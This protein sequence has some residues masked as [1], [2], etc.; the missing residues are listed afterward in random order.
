[1]KKIILGALALTMG[2]YVQAQSTSSVSQ[3]GSGNSGDV[4]QTSGD[5]TSDITVVGNN[6]E[7][8]VTQADTDQNSLITI[9]GLGGS[10]RNTV[11]VNQLA[12]GTNNNATVDIA[13]NTNTVKVDQL[14]SNNNNPGADKGV[15]I[16]GNR[17][18]V[19]LE[20]NG[21]NNEGYIK[22]G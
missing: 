2:V 14:G 8:N 21:D 18:D 22:I 15:D 20:Q 16:Y 9:Q 19:W 10:N 11:D 3:T 5:H 17:N 6:N 12:T 4:V 7:T 13:G 1:M